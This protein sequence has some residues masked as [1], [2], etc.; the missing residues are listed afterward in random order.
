MI[1]DDDLR[2]LRRCIELA[3]ERGSMLG[4]TNRAAGMLLDSSAQA[5]SDHSIMGRPPTSTKAFGTDAPSREPDSIV[6]ACSFV[7]V[8]APK[9]LIAVAATGEPP[10]T[11][12]S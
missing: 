10:S 3:C 9:R 7:S 2:H 8:P 6:K 5:A 11:P 12:P 4:C 1:N